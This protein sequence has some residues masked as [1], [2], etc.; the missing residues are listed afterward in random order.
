MRS[1]IFKETLKDK[2]L[3]NLPFCFCLCVLAEKYVL[4]HAKPIFSQHMGGRRE[5]GIR[6]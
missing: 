4:W 6:L 2:S 3:V 5:A 1:E